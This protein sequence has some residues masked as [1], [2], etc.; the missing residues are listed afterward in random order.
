MKQP[1]ACL[2][3]ILGWGL[4]GPHVDA[5]EPL[6]APPPVA[7][8]TLQLSLQGEI[9]LSD[10]VDYVSER[11]SLRVLYDE[12]LRERSINLVAPDPIPLDGLPQLLQSV[13]INEGLVV[14]D[15]DEQGFKRIATNDQIPRIARPSAATEDLNLIDAATPLTRVFVLNETKPSSLAELI[16]PFL[17]PQGSST[18]P[19]DRSGMLIITDIA[20]NIRRVEQLIEILD[21]GQ[22][23]VEIEFISARNV[24][25]E[26]LAE[27]LTKILQAKR[28]ALGSGEEATQGLEV[29]IES[30]TNSL[31]LVGTKAEIAQASELLDR[32]DR[33]LETQQETFTLRYYSPQRLDE[34]VRGI[35]SERQIKPPYQSR[36]EGST[37]I[38]DASPEV[39]LLIRRSIQQLDTR[40]APDEQS[41]VRFYKI[42]NVSAQE[43]VETIRGIGGNV[44]VNSDRPSVSPRRQ[45]TNDRSLPGPNRPPN[46]APGAAQPVREPVP[47]PAVMDD[48]FTE[49]RTMLDVDAGGRAALQ[50]VDAFH[51][52]FPADF[53]A[54]SGSEENLNGLVGAANVT[55]DLHTNTIIVV[56]EPEVQ[57]IYAKLIE[58]L[59]VR[60][61]QVLIEARIVIIDTS[62][63]YTLGVEIS[64]GDRSGA[65][66][67]FNFS[68]YGL[69]TVNPSSGA[70]NIIPGVGFNGTLVDPST[71]DVVVRALANHR[72]ARVL[73]TPRLLIN[74]NAEGQ[75]TSVLE[76]PFT[77]VNASQTV[78]T[79]SFAGFAEAG[80]TITATP[81]I[82]EDNYLQVDYVV[83]LNSFTGTG[84]E[85]VPPPRQT[86]EIQSSVTVPD[87]YTIIVGGLTSKN[88]SYEIDTIPWLERIPIVKDLASLQQKSWSETS[89]FV[90]LKPVILREDKFKDLR[91]LSDVNLRNAYEPTN[92]PFTAPLLVD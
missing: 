17:S 50:Q 31:I 78:A 28:R 12:S 60:R 10:F 85:G 54:L 83:T 66:R 19:L 88:Q 80:T 71:A 26:E 41:P 9:P 11:L 86:N 27:Q 63:D 92:F 30:R 68:S 22:A 51:E 57:R 38:V 62:D 23:Q 40:A 90:F 25:V 52:G 13:L 34:L 15:T 29:T 58:T 56:A 67:L 49:Q 32:L 44:R 69:S 24:A 45:T 46:F 82:S 75:L 72:R 21:A 65:R 73:S 35:L 59:D 84:T 70:L 16:T 5:Q 55:V 39:L 64:G 77:S 89:L 3:C 1:L 43:L 7:D 36:I 18:I 87:G 8:A 33:D 48:A 6:P 53:D 2:V 61:P 37:I 91:Y 47:P 74:D 81:T 42:K 20:R 79:T 76:V 14:T 4:L